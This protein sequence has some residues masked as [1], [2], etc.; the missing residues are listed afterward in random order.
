MITATINKS[1]N[2][3]NANQ[4]LIGKTF[5]V[6]SIEQFKVYNN[7]HKIVKLRIPSVSGI[8]F[9][10]I[11]VSFSEVDFHATEKEV[12]EFTTYSL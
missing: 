7:I 2:E 12:L 9:D 10:R 3:F 6:D 5:E 1:L 8:G 4:S 11:T